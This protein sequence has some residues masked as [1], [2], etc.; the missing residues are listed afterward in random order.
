MHVG[1]G[2]A[3]ELVAVLSSCMMG[4]LPRLGQKQPGGRLPFRASAARAASG[5]WGTDTEPISSP[6]F[7]FLN[8]PYECIHVICLSLTD[9]FHLVL[10]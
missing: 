7:R 1:A 5:Y 10:K 9:L 4:P 6:L 3:G 2:V 8:S